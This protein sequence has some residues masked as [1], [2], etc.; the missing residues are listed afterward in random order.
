MEPFGSMKDILFSYDEDIAFTSDDFFITTGIDFME[1]EVFK[2]LITDENAWKMSPGLG[3]S[4]EKFIGQPNTR[5]TGEALK[6]WIKNKLKQTVYP[7]V[8]EVRIVPSNYT[9]LVGFIDI[10]SGDTTFISIPF[11]FD[12]NLGFKK[13]NRMDR[14]V[15]VVQSQKNIKLNTSSIRRP[16]KYWERN[17]NPGGV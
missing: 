16:N 8:V 12:F 4:L 17:R 6:N 10:Y 14:F 7:G 9:Q 2:L 1:R 13:V 15:N 3:A 11:E 5:E